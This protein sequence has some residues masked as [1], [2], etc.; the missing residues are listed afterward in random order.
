M[1][2]VEKTPKNRNVSKCLSFNRLVA[3]TK[4]GYQDGWRI[5]AK[6][7]CGKGFIV[8]RRGLYRVAGKALRARDRA[9]IALPEGLCR[10]KI[11]SFRLWHPVFEPFPSLFQVNQKKPKCVFVSSQ[12]IVTIVLRATSLGTV[13]KIGH[14][15]RGG[16]KHSG[17][18]GV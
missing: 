16:R 2:S 18:Q 14:P 9:F 7:S 17:S 4:K 11:H 5:L 12:L 10:M 8:V 13:T 6:I 3:S 15:S 1:F